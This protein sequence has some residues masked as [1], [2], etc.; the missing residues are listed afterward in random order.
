MARFHEGSTLAQFPS[1]LAL[2]A[3]PVQPHPLLALIVGGI[4]RE[5]QRTDIKGDPVSFP[6]SQARSGR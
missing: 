2:M 5:S 4:S 3:M 1:L 6:S